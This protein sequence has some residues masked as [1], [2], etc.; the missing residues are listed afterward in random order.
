[1]KAIDE[2]VDD[3]LRLFR[4]TLP[5]TL[6]PAA[7]GALIGGIPIAMVLAD[8][9]Q[10][11]QWATL[12]RTSFGLALLFQG[13]VSL[14]VQGMLLKMLALRARNGVT[15][16][17]SEA[18]Q[19]GVA[20][21]PPMLIASLLYFLCCLALSLLLVLPGIWMMVA[22]VLTPVAIALEGRS[23]VAAVQ[24]SVALLRDKWWR[25]FGLLLL[26]GVVMVLG[27]LLCAALVKP[28]ADLAFGGGWPSETALNTVIGAVFT[29]LINA[30]LVV[31]FLD[32]AGG[33]SGA[34][35]TQPADRIAA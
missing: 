22:G 10:P 21:L 3:G 11:P 20:M 29:P 33:A 18:L 14:V 35:E 4:E 30:L 34:P 1:M 2:L 17:A 6:L 5:Q 13:V 9:P 32:Y 8:G 7:L 19:A 12:D 15:L 28:L 26:A 31:V 27:F 16:P 23:P 25:T 24:R